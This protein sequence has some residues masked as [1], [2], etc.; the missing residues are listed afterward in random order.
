MAKDLFDCDEV[1]IGKTYG[2]QNV[3]DQRFV[4]CFQGVI[5]EKGKDV[6]LMEYKGEVLKIREVPGRF[7]IPLKDLHIFKNEIDLKEYLKHVEG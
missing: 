7:P 3:N 4:G 1:V 2:W 6:L 5:E